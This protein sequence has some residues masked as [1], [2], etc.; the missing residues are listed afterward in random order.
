MG[1]RKTAAPEQKPSKADKGRASAKE[2]FGSLIG[3]K[4]DLEEKHR[5]NRF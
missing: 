2:G 1:G 3:E 5:Q 4:K